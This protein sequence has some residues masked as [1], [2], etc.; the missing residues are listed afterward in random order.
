MENEE[1]T[2]EQFCDPAYRRSQQITLKSEATWVAFMELGGL[3]N[4]SALARQYFNRSPG[5]LLQRL[6]GNT[7]FGKKAEFREEDYRTLAEALRDIARRLEVHADEIEHA[8]M[9]GK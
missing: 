3:L 7:V 4:T 9:T 6:N 2:F 8:A 5:W 1:M